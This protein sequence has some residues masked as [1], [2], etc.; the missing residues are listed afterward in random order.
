MTSD[1]ILTTTATVS[2]AALGQWPTSHPAFFRSRLSEALNRV[3]VEATVLRSITVDHGTEFQSQALNDWAYSCGAGNF[4]PK[5]L[6]LALSDRA[7]RLYSHRVGLTP[8]S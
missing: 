3:L 4:G 1:A 2:E 6:D 5:L 8:P 7:K